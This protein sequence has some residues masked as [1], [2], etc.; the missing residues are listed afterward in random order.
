MSKN[1][2]DE[3]CM[4][5]SCFFRFTMQKASNVMRTKHQSLCKQGHLYCVVF[6]NYC[7]VSSKLAG[8]VHSI[9]LPWLP[10]SPTP[11]TSFPGI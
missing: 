8:Y 3:F 9:R 11:P 2:F 5:S 6:I 7:G 4:V 10:F 1:E